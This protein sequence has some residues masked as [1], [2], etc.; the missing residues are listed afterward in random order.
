[1]TGEQSSEV[2]GAMPLSHIPRQQ[3]FPPASQH[4]SLSLPSQ[5][6]TQI[7]SAP[8][9]AQ[10]LQFP[11]VS[12]S[13]PATPSDNGSIA[14]SI[15]N[16]PYGTS[17]AYTPSPSYTGYSNNNQTPHSAPIS[18][19]NS[20][21]SYVP[22]AMG[23]VVGTRT[24]AFAC[25][26]FSCGRYFKRMEHLKRHLRTHTMEKPYQCERCQKR[27]SRSDNLNQHM[28]THGRNGGSSNNGG[29]SVAVAGGA[30]GM[31]GYPPS[32]PEF[33]MA[34]NHS[35]NMQGQQR[36]ASF[37]TESDLGDDQ[38]EEDMMA[39]AAAARVCEVDALPE[40]GEGPESGELQLLSS[41]SSF[42]GSHFVSEPTSYIGQSSEWSGQ[43]GLPMQ[44]PQASRSFPP[45][46][47]EP[48]VSSSA[49]TPDLHRHSLG[50]IH[51]DTHPSPAYSVSSA[52]LPTP[53]PLQHIALSKSAHNSVHN[54]P[55]SSAGEF[56]FMPPASASPPSTTMTIP[57]PASGNGYS[58][59]APSQ[60][61]SFDHAT[62]SLP[63]HPAPHSLYPPQFNM[64]V[65]AVSGHNNSSGGNIGPIRRH[66][67]A[68]PSLGKGFDTIRRP[69]STSGEHMSHVGY[70]PPYPQIVT[71]SDDY[72][73]GSTHSSPLPYNN[74]EYLGMDMEPA[75]QS[76]RSSIDEGV[77]RLS[78]T[79]PEVEQYTL[80]SSPDEHDM[81][82]VVQYASRP[83]SYHG[84]PDIELEA[85][86]AGRS[87][88]GMYSL[89]ESHQMDMASYYQHEPQLISI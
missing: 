63:Y 21:T 87:S 13:I 7:Y 31:A 44:H 8:S 49:T 12:Q 66:R 45:S 2:S 24:K 15:N 59:S 82:G 46:M 26:L 9:S 17:P 65:D 25:P 76:S 64:S 38:E 33:V 55:A 16:S 14:N 10:S 35:G 79:G 37:K 70:N 88:S 18:Y 23:A 74:S 5:S 6:Q 78:F 42:T 77:S 39:A 54:S 50:N 86:P 51:T 67:S 62:L 58:M 75:Y 57:T 73:G 27:F 81:S 43:G 83:A 60:K 22:N 72:N 53:S 4:L 69:Q 80:A 61:A 71:P 30:T 19:P 32:Q 48:F 3:S 34:S 20:Q 68:T 85:P 40:D 29:V 56:Q 47:Y 28:R 41:Q 52:P 84:T 11:Q 89:D 1:L 36:L